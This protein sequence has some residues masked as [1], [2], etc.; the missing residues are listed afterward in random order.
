MVVL[1]GRAYGKPA[2][3][4]EARQMLRQLRGRTHSVFTAVHLIHRSAGVELRGFS[5]TLVTMRKARAREI[6]AYV[7]SGEVQDKAGAYAIQGA[8]SRLVSS[9]NGPYDNVV[10]MPLQLVRRLLR[11]AGVSLS[12]GDRHQ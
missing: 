12:A 3:I 5:R 1:D 2:G 10:G 8:G 4:E 11:K 9:I 6:D 7:R